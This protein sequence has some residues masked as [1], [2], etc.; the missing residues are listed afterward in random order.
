MDTHLTTDQ[1]ITVIPGWLAWKLVHNTGASFGL[2]SG[3]ANLLI[4]INC[5]AILLI[6]YLYHRCVPSLPAQLG[7]SLLI[8]GA[9]GNL[10]SRLCFGYV[11]DF[12]SFHACPVI[13]NIADVEIIF[14]LFLL[15]CLHLK[16]Q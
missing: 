2:L 13:F 8:G 4:S 12:I 1:L 9:F 6:L 11:V 10:V 3:D 16:K 15:L 14:G 7:F 5:S